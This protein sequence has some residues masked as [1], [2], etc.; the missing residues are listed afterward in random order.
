MVFFIFVVICVG[1]G[2]FLSL[3]AYLN[4]GYNK[5]INEVTYS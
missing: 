1:K 4:V 2:L 3:T 5:G